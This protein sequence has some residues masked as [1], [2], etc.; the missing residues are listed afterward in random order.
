LSLFLGG[1]MALTTKQELFV[2]AYCAN[3]FNATQAAI[4]AYSPDSAR[5]IGSENLTKPAVIDEIDRYKLSIARR[6]GI[7]VSGLLKELEEARTIALTC[8]TPQTS[9]AVS[10][11][12]SKAKLAGLDKQVI[13]HTGANGGPIEHKV[14]VSAADKFAEILN[15]LKD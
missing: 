2:S 12:M 3:G 8:E 1:F 7:T 9:A 15:G 14:E 13:E 6:H 10:A 4:E 11:T 5:E